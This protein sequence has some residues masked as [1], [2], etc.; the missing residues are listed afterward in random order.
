VKHFEYYDILDKELYFANEGKNIFEQAKLIEDINYDI[1]NIILF[2]GYNL[3]KYNSSEEY[4]ESY[5][6]IISIAL[7]CF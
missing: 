4:V 6:N 5:L 7:F 2:N 3:D 1:E